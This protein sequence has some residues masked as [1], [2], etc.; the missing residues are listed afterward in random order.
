MATLSISKDYIQIRQLKSSYCI[1]ISHITVAAT[2][3]CSLVKR[4]C[5]LKHIL[6]CLTCYGQTILLYFTFN[7]F[8]VGYHYNFCYH[9]INVL[10]GIIVVTAT[11]L[12]KS[13]QKFSQSL[14]IILFMF[15]QKLTQL[16]LSFYSC[17]CVCYYSHYFIYHHHN[18][19][20]H[21]PL[22]QTIPIH[23]LSRLLF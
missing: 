23:P 13:Y 4:D 19:I 11:I 10:V 16:L 1:I 15:Y 3:V 21:H 14:L 5:V 2:A 22:L 20:M 9:Y 17:P 12:L 8:T 6:P 18:S 7:L